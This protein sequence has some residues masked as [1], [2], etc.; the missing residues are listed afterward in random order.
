MWLSHTELN[1]N[2]R[3]QISKTVLV[4]KL[5]KTD[6]SITTQSEH[7][8]A[9]LQHSCL[10]MLVPLSYKD[11]V[12]FHVL[13]VLYRPNIEQNHHV[14]HIQTYRAIWVFLR[15]TWTCW[16]AEPEI[17]PPTLRLMS[18]LITTWV[19][20]VLST[21]VSIYSRHAIKNS[22][23]VPVNHRRLLYFN[24]QTLKM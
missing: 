17:K 8:R 5:C 11:E 15:S 12:K 23:H 3:G 14:T 2:S 7:R 4:G 6:K 13:S 21:V 24:Y 18:W 22:S 16:Q 1:K 19:T 10:C 20:A 9:W